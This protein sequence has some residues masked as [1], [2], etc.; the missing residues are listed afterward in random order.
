VNVIAE[1]KLGLDSESFSET[2][3]TLFKVFEENQ[4][5]QRTDY[6]NFRFLM[7]NAMSLIPNVVERRSRFVVPLFFR[8]LEYV[9]FIIL[10]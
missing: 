8:F 5:E 9:L 4:A 3:Q 6:H 2:Y 10:H 1:N 7:W